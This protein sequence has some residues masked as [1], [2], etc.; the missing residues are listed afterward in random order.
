MKIEPDDKEIV[1]VEQ[2]LP[3]SM[4]FTTARRSAVFAGEEHLRC[5]GTTRAKIFYA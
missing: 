1:V 2:V 5:V 3:L 4:F